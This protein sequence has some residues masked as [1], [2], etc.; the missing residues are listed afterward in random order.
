MIRPRGRS[1]PQAQSSWAGRQ[2]FAAEKK[3]GRSGW[4]AIKWRRRLYEDMNI[5]IA[6]ANYRMLMERTLPPRMGG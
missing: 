1:P 6:R 5:E 3:A 4:D 2:R